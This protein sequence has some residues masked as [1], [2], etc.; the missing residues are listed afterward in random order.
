MFLNLFFSNKLHGDG[1]KNAKKQPPIIEPE[2]EREREREKE[3]ERERGR[4]R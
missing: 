3:R 1:I 4:G 2:R